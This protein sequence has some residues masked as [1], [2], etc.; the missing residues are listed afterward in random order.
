MRSTN[1]LLI[2]V[3]LSVQVFTVK[4]D[5]SSFVELSDLKGDS[6]AESL[7]Q[8]INTAL[9]NKGGRI[10]AIQDLLVQLLDKL[11]ADQNT[12][13]AQWKKREAELNKTIHDTQEL[14]DKLA[15]QIAKAQKSLAET[16]T[17]IGKANV[18]IKQ[19]SAQ[20]TNDQA[21]VQTLHLKRNSDAAIY[22]QNVQNHQDLILALDAVIR[23]LSK[24]RGSI[25]GNGRPAHVDELSQEKRDQAWKKS[26]PALLEVFSE[27][28]L[29]SFAQVAT[30]ADQD[31]LSKLIDMLAALKRSTQ[32]SL[33]DD[34]SNEEDSVKHFKLALTRL[35]S[36]ITLLNATLKRQREN[37][38]KYLRLKVSL[39]T[40]IRDKSALKAKNEKFLAQTKEIK[41]QEGL[42]YEADKRARN[43]E[44]EIIRKLQKIV[45]QKLARMKEFLRKRVNQ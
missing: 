31:A 25:S 29:T 17:K 14:I 40:E 39:Q 43:R 32:K 26:H 1:V 7:I 44:K 36:D 24:L 21:M 41:R 9:A 22:K 35:Q 13:D 5:F 34:D 42:K 12:A 38:A 45:D 18:N 37:L 23:E 20:L 30:E 6:Y 4:F 10:E 8:T 3:L 2:L 28:D 19:Y 11:I 15:A 33:A 27:S 16:I